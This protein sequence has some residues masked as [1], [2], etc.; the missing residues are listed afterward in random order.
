MKPVIAIALSPHDEVIMAEAEKMAMIVDAGH[1]ADRVDIV[2]NGEGAPPEELIWVGKKFLDILSGICISNEWDKKKFKIVTGNL[3][4]D[5]SVWPNIEIR[6]PHIVNSFVPGQTLDH[7]KVKNIKYH[8]GNLIGGSTPSRLFI[9]SQLFRYHASKTLQTFRRDPLNPGHASHLYIDQ[10]IFKFS[11]ASLWR[12]EYLDDIS[13]LLKASPLEQE[14]DQDLLSRDHYSWETG[15]WSETMLSWYNNF[16][17]DIVCETFVTGTAFNLSEKIARPLC[18]GNPFI[19]MGPKDHLK[20]IKKLGFK[21]FSG[22]WD[23]SYDHL[24]DAQRCVEIMRVINGLS[25][26]PLDEVNKMLDSM[27]DILEHNKTRYRELTLSS[28]LDIFPG[29]KSE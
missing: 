5:L 19:V 14:E 3:I 8:F 6:N 2:F 15:A 18:M 1:R 22:Y 20:N 7:P 29:V 21:T 24:S 13:N 23:E 27:Q 16:F 25:N 11:S 10:L 17:C 12:S 28:V 4:Q 9:S 26:L